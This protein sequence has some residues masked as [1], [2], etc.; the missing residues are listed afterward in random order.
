MAWPEVN[1]NL[2]FPL[3]GNRFFK[4]LIVILETYTRKRTVAKATSSFT[5]FSVPFRGELNL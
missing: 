2:S 4:Y 5:S 1:I 3:E